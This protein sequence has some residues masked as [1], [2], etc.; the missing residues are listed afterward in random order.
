MQPT[1]KPFSHWISKHFLHAFVPFIARSFAIAMP[2]QKSFVAKSKFLI[3]AVYRD[4][5]FFLKIKTLFTRIFTVS[6]KMKKFFN[7]K[8]LSTWK[9][10]NSFLLSGEWSSPRELFENYQK[11]GLLTCS[12]F[13]SIQR[14]LKQRKGLLV[15]FLSSPYTMTNLVCRNILP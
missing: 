2:Y 8:Y 11:T 1:E 9:T 3:V 10:N 14:P 13:R 6:K 5:Q 15:T 12:K 7:W 4:V